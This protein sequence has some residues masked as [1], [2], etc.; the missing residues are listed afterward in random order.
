MRLSQQNLW[1]VNYAVKR[2][3]S[4]KNV[5]QRKRKKK[6]KKHSATL[7][8]AKAIDYLHYCRIISIIHIFQIYGSD[9]KLHSHQQ[10][11]GGG[12]MQC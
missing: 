3:A 12:G 4:D 9:E 5:Q 10:L 7:Y 2:S 8:F 1:F 6:K 11:E